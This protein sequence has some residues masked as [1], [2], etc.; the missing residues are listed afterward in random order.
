MLSGIGRSADLS[1]FGIETIVDLPDVGHNLQVWSLIKSLGWI[2]V[3][4]QI[5]RI[6]LLLPCPSPLTPLTRQPKMQQLLPSNSLNGSII[7]LESLLLYHLT[8]L[9]GCDYLKMLRSSR[10]SKIQVLVLHLLT[11]NLLSLLV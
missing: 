9:V 11:F 5:F 6:M 8:S 3:D 2:F 1:P 10:L 7:I 4:L